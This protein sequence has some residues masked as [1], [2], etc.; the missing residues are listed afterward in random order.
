M[1]FCEP[2]SG[3]AFPSEGSMCCAPVSL[4]VRFW[5][6]PV[7]FC[8]GEPEE[9]A[10]IFHPPKHISEEGPIDALEKPKYESPS[11]RSC[12]TGIA[13]GNAEVPLVITKHANALFSILFYPNSAASA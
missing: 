12:G 6:G 10:R 9:A 11:L 3:T 1:G 2:A 4:I 7:L 8:L 5:H 13:A